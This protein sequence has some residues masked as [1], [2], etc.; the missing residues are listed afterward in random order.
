MSNIT[1]SLDLFWKKAVKPIKESIVA[2]SV[3]V[4]STL[5]TT[6]WTEF[7][8]EQSAA[9]RA[10]DFSLFYPGD[11]WTINGTDYLIGELDYYYGRG[12]TQHHLLMVPRENVDKQKMYGSNTVTMG[13]GASSMRNSYIKAAQ[14][15]VTTAFGQDHILSHK[16]YFGNSFDVSD[17]AN[18]KA[19]SWVEVDSDVDLMSELHV[20]GA[21]GIVN[22]KEAFY[23]YHNFYDDHQ[24]ALY[25]LNPGA[26]KCA[27]NTYTQYSWL[28]DVATSTSFCCITNTGA[29]GTAGASAEYGVRPAFCIY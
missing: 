22:S 20:F 16:N 24:I 6:G 27:D 13:Y 11:Y 8:K 15:I 4:P 28:R 25:K 10:G 23:P 21:A 2:Q 29:S 5:P 17:T 19:K 18:P 7:T 26:R 14:K 9:I 1:K 12:T 3:A